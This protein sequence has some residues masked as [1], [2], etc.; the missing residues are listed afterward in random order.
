LFSL[1]GNY[2]GKDQSSLFTNSVEYG[3][4]DLYNQKTNTEFNEIKNTINLDYTKPFGKNI[5]LE[6]GAQYLINGVSNDYEVLNQ[7]AGVYVADLGLTNTFEYNQNVLGLYGTGSYEK[8][9]WGLKAGLRAEHTDLS[10]LLINTNESNN[11]K[12][13]NF[14]PS[15]HTSY[16]L[17]EKVS[18]QAGYSSRIFRP[19]L[20]D[21]NPFFNISNNY[22]IKA[23]NPNLLP[24]YTDSYEIASIFIF[25]KTSFNINVYDKYTTQVIEEV[26]FFEDGVNTHTPYNLGTRN[27]VGAE[28]N[29]KYTPNKIFSLH[30]DANYN[31]FVRKGTFEE[32]VFD[33]E[34]DQWQTKL[35]AK[36]KLSKKLDFELSGNHQSRVQNIQGLVS[37][38]VYSNLGLRYKILNGKGVLNASVRDIF[39]SRYREITI[40]QEDFYIYSYG[41]RGRFI[42]LGFSYGFGKGEA[43][44][45][46]GG[47]KR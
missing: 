15:L 25:K 16:K 35:T 23:G 32:M 36:F 26:S 28:L 20:W 33:F 40:D 1:I 5:T 47:R 43:M 31:Y 4:D 41:Q 44:Q 22:N 3:N 11:Q 2:F 24:E 34:G 27:T 19:R 6:T 7:V 14:F 29:F 45:Y 9:K 21:L 37:G 42:T 12:F 18:F 46:S 17:N 30:G 10:T 13:L 39:A 38:N 8:K